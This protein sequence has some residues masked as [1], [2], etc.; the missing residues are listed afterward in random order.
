MQ[1]ERAQT[2]F[3]WADLRE[4]R[5]AHEVNA[6]WG[7]GLEVDT[8]LRINAKSMKLIS[9]SLFGKATGTGSITIG[10]SF[11]FP[12]RRGDRLNSLS[13]KWMGLLLA[14]ITVALAWI[15]AAA[16][17]QLPFMVIQDAS[18]FEGDSGT[19]VL[20]LPVLFIGA[21]NLPVTGVV[22]AIPMS[23]SGFNTPVGAT[24]CGG[25]NVDFEQFI[26]VPFSIP[27]NT[28]NGTLSVNIAIC[29][30]T[31]IEPDEHIFVFLSNVSGADCSSLEGGCSALGTIVNNDGPPGIRINNIVASTVA[32][33]AKTV[34]F[35]VSLHHPSPVPVSINYAT[36]DGTAE[37]RT[38][39]L[40][41]L[42]D[43]VGTRGT[44]TIPP[45]TLSANIPVRI[46]G[47]GGGTFFMDLSAPVNG[48]I[49]DATGQCTISIRTL[50]IANGPSD[51]TP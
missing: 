45:N 15:P 49:V 37:A 26:N 5:L 23:G 11:C 33:V 41:S 20:K 44:L 14:A 3:A 31:A 13:R 4:M 35:T 42:G 47:N 50:T 8:K 19:T 38:L 12:R 22:S 30:D 7:I 16:P 48:T 46:L 25:A 28:P 39:S 36:R 51:L 24:T 1:G 34:Y 9:S 29:G 27:A 17:A 43:Y 40:V 32:R 21:Q 6:D 10:D 2:S 18:I